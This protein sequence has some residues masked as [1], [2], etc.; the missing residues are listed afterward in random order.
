MSVPGLWGDLAG[1][2]ADS[3]GGVGNGLR[4]THGEWRT[5]P[6]LVIELISES[7]TGGQTIIVSTRLEN[8]V[9]SSRAAPRGVKDH[10]I[11]WVCW[12]VF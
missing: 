11:D 7:K 8:E 3:E 1:G 4:H 9:G 2:R 12:R 5:L 10:N 6:I